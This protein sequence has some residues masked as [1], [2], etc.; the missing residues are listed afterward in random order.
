M[1]LYIFP[2]AHPFPSINGSISPPITRLSSPRSF[3]THLLLNTGNILIVLNKTIFTMDLLFSRL[4]LLFSLLGIQEL[5]SFSCLLKRV[6]VVFCIFRW[7]AK[8]LGKNVNALGFAISELLF[9]G[10]AV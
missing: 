2:K 7:L 4:F 8:M 6:N 3:L 1:F 5:G 10:A 9:L